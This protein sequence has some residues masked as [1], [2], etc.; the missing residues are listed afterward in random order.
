MTLKVLNVSNGDYKIVVGRD[1]DPASP[2]TTPAAIIL[3]T[4]GQLGSSSGKVWIYGDLTVEGSTSYLQTTNTNILDRVITLN[5]G[6]AS[7][8]LNPAGTQISGIE[9]EGVPGNAAF[10]FNNELSHRNSSFSLTNGSFDFRIGTSRAGI[11]VSSINVAN[12]QNLYLINQGT[13]VVTVQGTNNYEVNILDYPDGHTPGNPYQPS[14]GPISLYS[15]DALQDALVNVIGMADYVKSYSYFTNITHITND[16]TEVRVFDAN[17]TDSASLN[18]PSYINFKVDAYQRATIDANSLNIP[19]SYTGFTGDHVLKLSHDG[20][21]AIISVSGGNRNI[22]FDP[23]GTGKVKV[24]SDLETTGVVQIGN[25]TNVPA[26]NNSYNVLYSESTLG[27]G[28][29]GLY[30][31]NPNTSGELVSRRRALGFSMIF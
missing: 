2:P 19:I 1:S 4:R 31:A 25:Q 20:T 17:S 27:M 8:S 9:I 28:K 22:E 6:G 14:N 16:N 30:F 3:D 18:N 24:S 29:T 13:G 21:N 5:S 10:I 23:S 26:T 11:Y 7:L 15:S 12:D